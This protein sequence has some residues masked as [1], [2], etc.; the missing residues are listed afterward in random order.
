MKIIFVYALLLIDYG[1]QRGVL[2][3]P[4]YNQAF[5]GGVSQSSIGEEKTVSL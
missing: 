5:L 2:D 1:V 3:R 4:P